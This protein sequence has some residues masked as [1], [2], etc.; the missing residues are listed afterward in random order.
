MNARTFRGFTLVELLV[1]IAIIGVLIALLLPAVQ[2]AREA[3]RR[4]QC[5]NHLAQLVLA[6]HN[7]ESANQHF[8]AGSINDTSPIRNVPKGYH[9]NWISATLPYLGDITTY[10]HIDFSKG[11]YDKAQNGP[12]ALSLEMLECPSSPINRVNNRVGSSHYVGIHNHCELPISESNTGAFI[13]NKPL[14]AANFHDGV[15]FTL[16]LAEADITP[17]SNLGWL[18]GTRAT[19]RNTGA[20][21]RSGPAI[22]LPNVYTDPAWLNTLEMQPS[23]AFDNI[24]AISAGDSGGEDEKEKEGE[25]VA[26][27]E[28][29]NEADF[30]DFEG[31]NVPL[32]QARVFGVIPN[33]PTLY[34]GGIG[35]YHP[36]GV[37]T[38]MGDGSVRFISETIGPVPYHQMGHR[39]DGQ[40]RVS[41]Y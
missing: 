1:V 33:D 28:N 19:L 41:E 23:E 15:A 7:Y 20:A 16:F 8:P 27:A 25:Q 21:P 32:L 39:S 22:G 36:G 29:L 5:M 30:M 40:L 3:A 13:L 11:V 14:S 10:D 26:E 18:S 34:V 38:A 2:Q 6:L 24:T 4:M 17:T 37:N 31:K 12:R 9:H 35:S